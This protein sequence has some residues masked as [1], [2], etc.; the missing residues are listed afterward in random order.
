M[1]RLR[2]QDVGEQADLL[3][4]TSIAFR[5]QKALTSGAMEIEALAEETGAKKETVTRTLR[6][7][8]HQGKVIRVD[9]SRW[10]LPRR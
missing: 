3:A 8:G 4:R 2:P 7:L 10:G 5:I 6:R 9:D 1:I